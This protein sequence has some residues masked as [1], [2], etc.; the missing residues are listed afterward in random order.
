MSV[1]LGKNGVVSASGEIGANLVPNQSQYNASSP[2]ILTTTGKDGYKWLPASSFEVEPSTTYTYSVFCDGTC[3]TKHA[4]DGS[5]PGTFGMWLYLCNTGNE[6]KS[7][8][9]GYDTPVC[10]N[11]STYNHVQQGQRHSWIYTTSAT[12]QYMSIRLNN[13]GDGT[14]PVTREY[15]GFK[16][17]KGNILT[18]WIPNVN[19]EDYVGNTSGFNEQSSIAQIT[20]SYINAPDFMEI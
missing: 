11:S 20:K 12:Q 18:A 14:N 5:E 16:V 2:Y 8:S 9:G 17:E 4:S 6:S 15:W 7:A 13:Y 19:D 10:F 1:S 3:A